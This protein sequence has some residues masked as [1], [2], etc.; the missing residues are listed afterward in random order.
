MPL[1]KEVIQHSIWLIKRQNEISIAFLEK[2]NQDLKEEY[3]AE[4]LFLR[5][6]ANPR[7]RY[8]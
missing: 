1:T 4:F 6:P 7:L 2:E 5:T 3:E 8:S